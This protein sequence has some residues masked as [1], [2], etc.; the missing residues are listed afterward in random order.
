MLYMEKQDI[1]TITDLERIA[2]KIGAMRRPL[3][4]DTCNVEL[5][6]RETRIVNAIG[7]VSRMGLHGEFKILNG[8]IKNHHHVTLSLGDGVTFRENGSRVL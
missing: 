6:E 7:K 4:F 8:K 3:D 2:D 1:I 5:D